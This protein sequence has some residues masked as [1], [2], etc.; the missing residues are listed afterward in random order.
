MA[1][2]SLFLMNTKIHLQTSSI[3]HIPIQNYEQDFTFIVNGKEYPTSRIVA[4]LL[5][6]KISR[7]HI[8]DPTIKEYWINPKTLGDFNN[9]LALVDFQDKD[10]TEKDL[11]FFS[12]IFRLLEIESKDIRINLTKN[13]DKSL[14]ALDKLIRDLSFG[15]IYEEEIEKDIAKV[16]EEL[17]QLKDD[18]EEKAKLKNLDI[19]IIERI[20]G[21]PN[22]QIDSEDQLVDIINELYRQ[23][24]E[25]CEL[26]SFVDFKNV[27]TS[28][29]REFLTEIQQDDVTHQTWISLSERL[30]EEV[31][32]GENQ[33]RY[34]TKKPKF[35]KEILFNKQEFDGLVNCLRKEGNIQDEVSITLSSIQYGDPQNLF[36]Y[37]N[38]NTYCYTNN[39]QDS[40]ICFE[41]KK[42]EIMPTNYT[43]RTQ[44]GGPN[45]LHLKSWNL[46]GSN[47]NNNWT[48]LDEEKDCSYL[49]G[50]YFTHTFGTRNE[51][52]QSFKYLRIHQTDKSWYNDYR[53]LMNCIEFYGQLI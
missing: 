47:D 10:I 13:D 11:P 7:L 43:I 20:F 33:K 3:L 24:R 26:Y 39:V 2:V 38:K 21:H 50:S 15:I 31:K 18:E 17:Y 4:D 23:D 19:S 53:L 49:N 45:F 28:K 51:E 22:L 40:W 25:Y 1:K 37:E 48:I 32:D 9:I 5:S 16:S 41:F 36:I 27:T 52:H 42:H 30:C 8:I 46:E 29:M 6:P 35:Y 34:K 44:S 12:E 14:T